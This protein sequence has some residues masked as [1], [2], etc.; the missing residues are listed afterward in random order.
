LERATGVEPAT[1]SLG[2][3]HST[4]ELR[5]LKSGVDVQLKYGFSLSLSTRVRRRRKQFGERSISRIYQSSFVILRIG[6]NVF[7]VGAKWE[8]E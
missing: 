3:W 7:Y 2:S 5:P 4:A 6:V 8:D 1:S